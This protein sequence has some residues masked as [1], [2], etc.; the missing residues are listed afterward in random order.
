MEMFGAVTQGC[1]GG[2]IAALRATVS[3]A[4][5]LSI[6]KHL[7]RYRYQRCQGAWALMNEQE[8]ALMIGLPQIPGCTMLG[9]LMSS[10]T[11]SYL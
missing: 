11:P 2:I 1:D 6:R 9:K 5:S 4:S 7:H 10:R 3:L 8:L